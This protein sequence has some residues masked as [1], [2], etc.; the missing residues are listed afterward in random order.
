MISVEEATEKAQRAGKGTEHRQRKVETEYCEPCWRFRL[1]G[2]GSRAL[3]FGA[4][5]PGGHLLPVV[6]TET[7][8]PGSAASNP[9]Q[10]ASPC[11]GQLPWSCLLLLFWLGLYP[12]LPL[13]PLLLLDGRPLS[14]LPND[15]LLAFLLERQLPHLVFYLLAHVLLVLTT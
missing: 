1:A 8:R 11:L 4:W 13:S 5:V 2:K 10:T 9:F 12:Q 6:P 7:G 14:W 15:C 3:A